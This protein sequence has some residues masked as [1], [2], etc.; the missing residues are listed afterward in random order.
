[1]A[2][3]LL[4]YSGISL[5]MLVDQRLDAALHT[6]FMVEYEPNANA[7]PHDHP[8]E[9]AYYVMHGEVEAWA[10]DEK[11]LMKPGDFLWAGVGCTHA[12]YNRSNTTVRWLETQ[13]PQPPARNSYRW[14]RDWEYVAE[15]TRAQRS[16]AMSAGSEPAARASSSSAARA[17]SATPSRSSTPTRAATSSSRAATRSARRASR[18]RSAARCA[19]SRLDISEPE[20]IEAALADFGHVDHLALVAVDRDYNSARDYD[21]ERARKIVTLKLI[22]YT[23]VAH[24]LFPRMGAGASAVLFGGL[25]SERPYPGSTS[26]TTVNGAVSSLIRTLAVELAPVRFNAI[27]PGIISDTPG[28]GGQEGSDREHREAHAGR[29]ARDDRGRRRRRRLPVHE[30]RRQRHQPRHRRRLAAD[31]ASDRGHRPLVAAA[32]DPTSRALIDAVGRA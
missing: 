30:P 11:Y 27:H 29:A 9:E 17:A 18:K 6:M 13:S 21:V 25:A 24:T 16:R 31:L 15:Q 14:A 2:T 4:V 3:A 23:E 7:H 1:M 19:G 5:K 32:C 12:F 26:I 28:V 8:L 10:D 20:T 22:G